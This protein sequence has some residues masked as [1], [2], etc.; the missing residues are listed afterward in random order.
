MGCSRCLLIFFN[1]IFAIS[2]II[3][4]AAGIRAEVN[5]YPYM[6]LHDSNFYTSAP[7]VLIVVGLFI[8][9]VS[10]LGCY[11]AAKES[12][13]MLM[14]FA[15]LLLIIF[16]TELGVGIAGYMQHTSLEENVLKN[17]N[18]TMK[19]YNTDNAVKTKFDIIQTDLQCCGINSP[20][21]WPSNGMTIPQSC[22]TGLEINKAGTTATCTTD[23]PNFHHMGCAEPL[24]AF[25]RSIATV[26][27]GVALGIAFIQL[28]GVI[29]ACCLARSVR[30]QYSSV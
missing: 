2:G 10:F 5:S 22:C 6:D 14:T 23:M 21:D 30:N 13:C 4:L 25:L 18:E 3:I 1:I 20:A 12:N 15:G 17:L 28:I 8:F 24:T 19:D 7:V 27:G 16:V 29:M 26:L 11:G 9:I